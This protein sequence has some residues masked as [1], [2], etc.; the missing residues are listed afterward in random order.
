M[1]AGSSAII[2]I[3][4][5]GFVIILDPNIHEFSMEILQPRPLG[6]KPRVSVQTASFK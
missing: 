3:D 5:V 2:W 1:P 6:S 4:L